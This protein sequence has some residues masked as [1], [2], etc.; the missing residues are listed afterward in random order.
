MNWEFPDVQARLQRGREN[1]PNCQN[2]LDYEESM[3]L[4]KNCYFCFTDYTKIFDCVDHK[5][6]ME[7]S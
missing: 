1:R 5:K 3:G 4:Q 2:L 7:N 6:T